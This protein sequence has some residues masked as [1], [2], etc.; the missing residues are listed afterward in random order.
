MN[1]M[2]IMSA[3][4]MRALRPLC[5]ALLLPV[6]APPAGAVV[7]TLDPAQR[8]QVISGW[9][10]TAELSDTPAAPAPPSRAALLDA[11]VEEIG[12]N[13]V[14]LEIRAGAEGRDGAARRFIAGTLPYARY[15]QRFY[16]AE[17]DNADPQVID[18]SGFDFSELDWHVT[19]SV[20]P[21][22]R[23]LQ[24]RGE[25]LIVNLTYVSFRD[26]PT[27]HQDPEEYAEFVLAT[28]LHL[29]S[30]FGF[31]PDFWEVIL[32]PDM[33]ENAWNGETIGRA[34]VAAARR[35]RQAGFTPAFIL[36]SVANIDRAVPLI[37]EIAR[38]PGAMEAVA[39]LSYHRYR[40]NPRQALPRLAARARSLGKPTSMLEYWF[41]RGTPQVLHEDLKV[42]G[43][44]AWQGRVLGGLV[45]VR[46]PRSSAPLITPRD[47]IRYNLQYFRYI[48]EGAQ[49]IGA[50]S[51]A[52]R[53]VDPLAFV[54]RNGRHVVVA[55]TTGPAALEIRGLPAGSYRTSYAIARGSMLRPEAQRI[56][57]GE[58]LRVRM[59][60]AGVITIFQEPPPR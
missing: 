31:V 58:S 45:D 59:P 28:Y 24:A 19:R 15:K 17:N 39:E 47:E 53:R 60:G 6:A 8:F 11:V 4:C 36:P 57:A 14:R 30:A 29:Q 49:R 27:L 34:V 32:E 3:P 12:I 40:G 10:A 33:S 46:N 43:A 20:L 37:D 22:R 42:G 38:I 16:M 51:D 13:R 56:A 26:G 55:L 18:W 48:R 23:R 1:I 2:N 21:L 44:V 9:E 52:P 5:A 25:R 41:G 54:N 7:I 50:R 35:L